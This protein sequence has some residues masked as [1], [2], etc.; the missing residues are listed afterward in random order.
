MRIRQISLVAA[1]AA[2]FASCE[3]S[4]P[5]VP[6][7]TPT[8]DS[9][10]VEAV[11][12]DL[13]KLVIE[14]D[15]TPIEGEVDSEVIPTDPLDPMTE[16]Y[17]ENNTFDETVKITFGESQAQV[18]ND[19][20]GVLVEVSGNHV[21]VTSAVKKVEYALSGTTDN[22]SLKIYSDFK[23]QLTLNG[24]TIANPSGAAINI[25]SGKHA[26]VVL[27]GENN[28]S[29]GERPTTTSTEDDKGCIFSEGE[30]LFSGS[31]SLNV[32]GNYKHGIASDDFILF[33]PGIVVNVTTANGAGIKA[34]D[35]MYINGGALNVEVSKTAAKAINSE[36]FVKMTGGR[37]IAKTSGDTKYDTDLND[38]SSAAGINADGDFTMTG[39]TVAIE[40]TGSGGKGINCKQNIVIS[41]GDITVQTK[42]KRF[43]YSSTARASAKG[44]K[45]VGNLTVNGGHIR[46]RTSGGVGSEGMESKG[47]LTI[48]AGV[49]EVSSYDDA[50]NA[51]TGLNLNGG[52]VYAYSSGNDA[53]DSNGPL[54]INGGIIV[55]SSTNEPEAAFDCDKN[56]FTV[57]GGVFVGIGGTTS[58]PTT[59]S[60]QPSIISGNKIKAGLS[61]AILDGDDYPILAY[62]I[63]R[64]FST[65]I[66]SS[67]AFA[68]GI[69]L[70]IL[71]GCTIAD[72]SKAF[73]GLLTQAEVSGGTT[74][75]SLEL[76]SAVNYSNYNPS[77]GGGTPPDGGGGTPPDGGG[78]TPPDG[79][80]GTPPDG[81]GG[82]PPGGQ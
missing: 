25:Q 5:T 67:S 10:D 47:N 19:V 36:S 53:I 72:K 62:T 27:N 60:Q 2:L 13:E 4:E 32:T 58:V 82:T 80:G 6:G 64:D 14:F 3:I 9:P 59:E 20:E 17:L 35:G 75:A 28:L 22:G 39:G 29:D 76:T 12:D 37:V 31:G 30:L 41:G 15:K 54:T 45:A 33:R 40:S 46:V 8:P 18:E 16:L 63:P 66:V 24:V 69:T 50:L 56:V 78:G 49:V 11:G 74:L 81:G 68:E 21:T 38:T 48:N 52:Y 43:V 26:F 57:N 73:H 23:Y 77:G 34:N 7:Y 79:G 42:G 71:S 61:M 51:V 55:A 44:I 1:F 65:M 70:K